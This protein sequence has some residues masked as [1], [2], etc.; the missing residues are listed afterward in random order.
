[1][2]DLT[3]RIP[4]ESRF[5]QYHKNNFNG[6]EILK[7]F[8]YTDNSH[9]TVASPS[10]PVSLAAGWQPNPGISSAKSSSEPD[11]MARTAQCHSSILLTLAIISR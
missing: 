9:Q 5:I 1:V 4:T 2:L 3:Y 7:K 8:R 11:L 6:R 10:F